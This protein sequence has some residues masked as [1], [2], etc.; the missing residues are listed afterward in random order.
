MAARATSTL[1]RMRRLRVVSRPAIALVVLSGLLL[2]ACAKAAS[3]DPLAGQT[4]TST[5]ER[6]ER[7]STTRDVSGLDPAEAFDPEPLDWAPCTY[8][9]CAYLDVPIDYEDPDAGRTRIH[10]AR[11]PADGDRIGALFVNPGG[12]GAG[13]ADFA[14]ILS[15]ILPSEIT[16]RFDIVG[17]DPRGTGESSPIDCGVDATELYGTDH[18]LED[19]ED[20]RALLEISKAYVDDCT[21]HYGDV[22]QHVGTRDVARDMNT[23]LR[24]MGE[25]EMNFLGFSYGTAIGQVYAD[26]FPDRVR[27]MI[28][29][30][31]LELGPS[32]IELATTQAIGFETALDRFVEYCRA[33]EGCQT[34]DDP[35]GAVE[36][37]I[38]LSERPGGIPAS[39]ADRPAGAGEVQMG[40]AMALYSQSLWGT[41][42]RALAEALEG[43]GSRLVDLADQ[44]VGI[45]DFEIYFGV[46]CLDFEWPSDPQEFF[47]AAK[48]AAEQAP[49]FGEAIV[50][51]YVRCAD[52]PVEQEPLEPVAAPG[53][54]P[55]LVISTT[56]DPATPFEAGVAVAERLE[57][58]VLVVNDGD[59]HTVV[60]DGNPCIDDI[61]VRYLVDLA[62]PED[63]TTC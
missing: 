7:P 15:M 2:G 36:R 53:T 26:L 32:G 6:D 47:A 28:L 22:L 25:E 35:L 60:A 11:A 49:H 56:G 51:D 18:T 63:G 40:L 4:T 45:G 42:D 44:Y 9:E 57:Q 48:A 52:W 24:A 39:R 27:A 50:N 55:I 16:D 46:N 23:V 41:L 43:D 30:G 58:G 38:E 1:G 54:P 12:P 3:E 37:V 21:L 17:V 33:A 13:G 20:E 29:D 59:G 62:V 19:E 8:G 61:V 14:A 34:A 5:T 31:V 10:V